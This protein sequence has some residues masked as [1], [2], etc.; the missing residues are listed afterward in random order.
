M[1]S[2]LYWRFAA[3]YAAFAFGGTIAAYALYEFA[4]FDLLNA[5][6]ATMPMMLAT[7][8]LGVWLTRA[9]GIGPQ[10]KSAWTLA[11]TL[12]CIGVPI[13][14]VQAAGVLWYDPTTTRW[15]LHIYIGWL[16]VGF[17][18]LSF[19]TARL[20]LHLGARNQHKVNARTHGKGRSA[21]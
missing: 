19:L 5:S 2:V 1:T 11:L 14:L 7:M 13:S 9:D 16:F 15:A 10:G 18:L 3:L 8:Q 4:G 6:V 20:F 12:T 21:K 17:V